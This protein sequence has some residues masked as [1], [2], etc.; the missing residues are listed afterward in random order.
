MMMYLLLRECMPLERGV[1]RH[2]PLLSVVTMVSLVLKGRVYGLFSSFS[3]P[4]RPPETIN[5]TPVAPVA[6][7]T[8]Q[9]ADD[10]GG[11][12]DNQFNNAASAHRRPE[13]RR[14]HRYK[15]NDVLFFRKKC[16]EEDA[17]GAVGGLEA[18]ALRRDRTGVVL[19][20][21]RAYPQRAWKGAFLCTIQFDDPP[22]KVARLPAAPGDDGIDPDNESVEFLKDAA[23]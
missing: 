8:Q 6:P 17:E 15:T 11:D 22:T 23:A 7:P 16:F 18:S 5:H 21:V 20:C 9:A 13:V 19:E 3:I 10:G 12:E 1:I 2:T 14:G 4:P